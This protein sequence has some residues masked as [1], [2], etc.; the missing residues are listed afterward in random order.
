MVV[1][2][3][4]EDERLLDIALIC[5]SAVAGLMIA[6]RVEVI[7]RKSRSKYYIVQSREMGDRRACR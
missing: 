1:S 7:G 2:R 3:E 5:Q 6:L 4:A